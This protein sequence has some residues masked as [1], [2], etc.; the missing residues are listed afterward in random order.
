LPDD[1]TASDM[2]DA[3]MAVTQAA[4]LQR[5]EVSAYAQAGHR[6]VH[7]LN[8][9]SFG[10]YLGIGAGAHS[11]ISAPDRIVREVRWRDPATYMDKALLG[12]AIS[13]ITEVTARAR[14]F[15]YM[16]NTL[17]LTEGFPISEFT[18]RTGLGITH[19]Q[20]EIE[21][22]E[23]MGLLARD[24]QRL[25]PTAKGLDFLSDLQALFLEDAS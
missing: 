18:E 24:L 6:C 22:A 10:D 4:G 20:Q 11:K 25:W 19:I 9:W 14:P 7:N 3:L 21:Q 23:K 8:Y 2:M 15:E 12:Q 1:D 17:R 16:L 13:N 5:Y